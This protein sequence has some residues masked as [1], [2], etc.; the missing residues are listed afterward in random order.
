MI[1]LS[2]QYGAIKQLKILLLNNRE[3]YIDYWEQT[4]KYY[5]DF[6]PLLEFKNACLSSSPPIVVMHQGG[7]YYF[8]APATFCRK[9][10]RASCHPSRNIQYTIL[11]Y[12]C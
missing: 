5:L 4:V 1:P 2:M 8:R 12:L 10:A 7:V 3:E 11:L 6:K 9:V